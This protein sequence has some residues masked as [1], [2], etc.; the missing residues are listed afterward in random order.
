MPHATEDAQRRFRNTIGRYPTGVS[1]VTS[2]AD[3]G[4]LLGMVV[5]TFSSVS[6]DPPLVSFMPARSSS[7]WAEI[8]KTRKFC[9]NVLSS[10][11]ELLCRQFAAKAPDRFERY[12]WELSPLGS[13][14]LHDIVCWADCT[15][16][17]IHEAG[18]H[19]IVVGRVHSIE[20]GEGCETN[21]LVFYRGGYGA[22]RHGSMMY[23]D[24]RLT[25]ELSLVDAVREEFEIVA[26]D[27]G[28]E[29]SA[30]ARYDDTLIVLAS[31]G[32]I[33][34]RD[35]LRIGQRVPLVAPLA[36]N[37][38]AWLPPDEVTAWLSRGSVDADG[39]DGK[40]LLAELAQFRAQG[41]AT[42]TGAERERE[43]RV[44]QLSIERETAHGD[45]DQVARLATLLAMLPRAARNDEI[46]SIHVPLLDADGRLR[47][48]LSLSG[49]RLTVT[50]AARRRTYVER[51]K[52]LAE[53]LRDRAGLD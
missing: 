18:D 11:Q 21:P 9:V 28:A 15:I 52:D 35:A 29:L 25:A 37:V 43:I 27:L 34:G 36:S 30:G 16:E 47:L 49:I 45:P 17:A 13:P 42:I 39:P 1:L 33:A 32:P 5:G 8:R 20:E 53:L 7:T 10:E 19:D 14:R 48:L 51:L 38:T 6:L 4:D 23:G 46:L 12:R 40:A 50:D 31:A 41:Y 24:A 44:L 2:R 22:F 3:E 26:Q